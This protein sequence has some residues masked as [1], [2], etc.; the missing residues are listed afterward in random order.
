MPKTRCSLGGVTMDDVIGDGRD[1]LTS[2]PA[3]PLDCKLKAGTEPNLLPDLEEGNNRK[4]VGVDSSEH[5]GSNCWLQN[6]WL[7][8]LSKSQRYPPTKWFPNPSGWSSVGR[9]RLRTVMVKRQEHSTIKWPRSSLSKQIK[10]TRI[11]K[12]LFKSAPS[13]DWPHVPI[14]LSIC[15]CS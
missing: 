1:V 2:V 15:L 7:K 8:S 11:L 10:N 14:P 4:A 6:E 5:E 3:V 12:I 13:Q 9:A